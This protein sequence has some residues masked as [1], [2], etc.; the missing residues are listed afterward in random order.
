LNSGLGH[1]SRLGRIFFIDTNFVDDET[2]AAVRLRELATQGWISLQKTDT[3]DT[4]L[5]RR[6][7]PTSRRELLA[8]AESYVEAFGT[9]R[10]DNSRRDRAMWAGEVGDRVEQVFVIF[11][12][13]TRFEG[14][15]SRAFRHKIGDAM[16][17]ATAIRYGGDAFVTRDEGLLDKSD[18][19][20]AACGGF[21]IMSPETA[22]AF[23][24]RL[25]TRWQARSVEDR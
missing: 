24:N 23:T 17:V 21:S 9:G 12:P 20:A 1:P 18:Q 19:I 5:Q 6:Q 10:W 16:H 8:A 2:P 11:F 3:L 4:E 22:L 15:T 25:K 13:E 7:E 14:N